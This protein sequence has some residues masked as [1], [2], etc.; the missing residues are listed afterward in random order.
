MT[1]DSPASRLVAAL[2][3]GGLTV[4]TAESLT[5]GLLAAELVSVPGVS[6]AFL[7][8]IV[9]YDTR[10]KHTLLGVDAE[11][12][13][14]TGP[15]DPLVAEQMAEGVRQACAV[16]GRPA[17]LGLA[18]T[19]V[20]GPDPDAQTGLPAGTVHLGIATVRGV[21]SV[22]LDLEGDRAAIR[23]ATVAAAIEEALAE[24][25]ALGARPVD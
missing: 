2:I 1:V 18:T 23:A 20:A 21:R 9:S 22:H 7:G 12:L 13:A 4:A 3:D 5:G 10:L 16:D 14:E 17:D 19:G 25:S 15:V 6:A 11:R 24:V 8:G